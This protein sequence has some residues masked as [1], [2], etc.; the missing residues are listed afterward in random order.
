[1]VVLTVTTGADPRA[2]RVIL[3]PERNFREAIVAGLRLVAGIDL[4]EFRRRFGVD[5]G[6]RFER[7]IAELRS[8]GL[9]ILEGG[10]LR[11]P[12]DRLLVSN[13][14]LAAFV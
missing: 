11:I 4:A 1:M 14:V 8:D 10:I 6:A 9:I 5:V 2:E 7:E 3:D 12:K 13:R